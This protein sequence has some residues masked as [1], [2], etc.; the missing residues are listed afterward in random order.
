M[1]EGPRTIELRDRSAFFDAVDGALEIDPA[2]SAVLTIDMHRGHLDEQLATMPVPGGAAPGLLERSRGLLDGARR[3]G[4]TIIHSVTVKRPVEAA[5][6]APF[7]AAVGSV[8]ESVAPDVVMRPRE[9]NLEGSPHCELMPE[10]GPDP[11]DFVLANKKQFSAFYAT[12]LDQLLALLDIST[13]IILGVGTNTC[14]LSTALDAS[15][16]RLKVVVASDCAVSLNGDDLHEVALE[17]MHRT[18][19]W[20]MPSPDLVALF[21]A[22]S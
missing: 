21:G 6:P 4:L 18:I 20:V 3:A 5:S 13:L 15:N 12:D 14:L 17:M 10:V 19:A 8:G 2:H 11:T 22:P 1:S 16:R 9:H 7:L